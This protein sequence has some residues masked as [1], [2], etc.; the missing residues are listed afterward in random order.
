MK[1]GRASKTALR[2][3]IRRA[4]HQLADHP[5]VL[6]DPIALPLLG[7]GFAR[8]LDRAMEKVAR[9]FRAFMAA[10]SRY[11]EDQLAQAVSEGVTQ[12]VV[13]GA[14]LDTF[15]YRNPFPSLRVFEVDF[16]ATQEWKR[17]LLHHARIKT[18]E[19]L[20]YVPLDFE[21]KTLAAGL[22]DAGFD[23]GRPAFFG[24]LG[25]VPYLTIDAFR[26]TLNDIARLPNGSGISFDFAFPPETLT[27]QR[28]KVFDTL[29]Q[30]VAAAGEPFQLFFTAESLESELH[31]LGFTRI[32]Q[33]DSERL[34]GLYFHNRAD[35]LRI[36]P[37]GIGMLATA[38]V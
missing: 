18:P 35:G 1:I 26:A 17:E 29:S 2:V 16:P 36:S 13:L 37:V 23:A 9:D 34:N 12:Y 31:A 15:A 38:W 8:D 6:D 10:R 4:A 5:P 33:V 30:R 25:V 14:G 3:A 19:S 28:R 27:P 7:P 11:V 32:E 21:H 20:T 24:W 22:A